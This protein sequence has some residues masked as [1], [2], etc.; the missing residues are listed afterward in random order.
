MRTLKIASS[1]LGIL[2]ISVPASAVAP[3]VQLHSGAFSI[4]VTGIVP[5]ICRAT[6]DASLVTPG[7]GPTSLG[8]LS[9]FCN[10]PNGYR[11]VADYSPS[12]ASGH[13]IVDGTSIELGDQ[14][15]TVISFS[16]EAAVHSRSVSLDVP[17]GAITG[18]LSVRI[19]PR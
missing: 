19:E 10:S 8:T 2:M 6:L 5:V 7:T 16:D 15:S 11:V 17:E 12:L 4:G 18:S 14:G 1:V 9:E 13:L 3:A